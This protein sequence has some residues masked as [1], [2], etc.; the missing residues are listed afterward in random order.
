MT[1]IEKIVAKINEDAEAEYRRILAEV[2]AQADGIL[3]DA[4]AAAH[5]A[6]EAAIAAAEGERAE[7][8]RRAVSMAGLDVRKMRLE[9]KQKLLQQAFDQALSKLVSLPDADYEGFLTALASNAAADGA[10]LVFSAKD[11]EKFGAAVVRR[12]NDALKSR[13]AAV[14]LSAETRNIPGGVIVRNGR[15]EV[16][17]AFDTLIGDQ[18]E[19]LAAEAAKILF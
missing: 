4:K 9:L 13:G 17:C 3:A 1:G 6:A 15:V 18:R 10:E 8:E 12:V 5:A 14:S 2:E 16:N 11:R 19:E 7:I